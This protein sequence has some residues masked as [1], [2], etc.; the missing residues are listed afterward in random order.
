VDAWLADSVN[1]R[2]TYHRTTREA[3]RE[4]LE[5]GVDIGRSRIAA[6]GQGFYTATDPEGVAGDTILRV[7]IRAQ[8]PFVAEFEDA[9]QYMEEATRRLGRGSTRLTPVIAARVRQ[10]LLALGHDAIVVRDGGGDGIDYV[11][12]LVAANVKVLQP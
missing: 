3:A 9:E 4:I 11:I 6:Y 1:K 7:A 10:E 2:V 12:A 8:H 5:H